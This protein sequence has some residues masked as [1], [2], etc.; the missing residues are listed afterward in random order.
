ML[1]LADQDAIRLLD[2]FDL[3]IRSQAESL[4]EVLR[5]NNAP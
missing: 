5:K 1:P 3:S 4:P 2:K